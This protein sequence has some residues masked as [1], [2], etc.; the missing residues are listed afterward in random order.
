VYYGMGSVSSAGIASE[1]FDVCFPLSPLSNPEMLKSI[2]YNHMMVLPEHPDAYHKRNGLVKIFSDSGGFQLSKGVETFIEPDK[3]VNHYHRHV[4]YGIGLDIPLS[5]HLQDT[6]WFMRMAR[7]TALNDKYI[8][9]HLKSLNSEA[10]IYDVSHGLTLANRLRFTE[11][12]M[13]HKAGVGLALGGI[14]QAN[15]D[16]AFTSQLMAVVNLSAVLDLTKGEYERYHVLG[17][18]NPFMI[19][20]YIILTA[21]GMAPFISSD[22][23]TY[24]QA[25]ISHSSLGIRHTMESK[26]ANFAIPNQ[27]FSFA[28][29]CNCPICYVAGN[30][31]AFKLAAMGNALHGMHTMFQMYA[32]VN[33]ATVAM[34]KGQIKMSELLNITAPSGLTDMCRALYRFT[35]DMGNGFHPAWAKHREVLEGFLRKSS[36]PSGLFKVATVADRHLKAGAITTKAIERYEEFH[37]I[38]GKAKG[39]K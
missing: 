14:G 36:A 33:E 23:S 30:P 25:A 8:A 2:G 11:Y 16:T 20:I 10:A 15:Y 1:A 12:I 26:I 34:L 24:A 22:S 29:P 35:M 38:A 37:G 27:T 13:K 39:A 5:R 4:D 7:V 6:E 28:L 9:G 31:L 17:T 21:L 3:L 18:T 32:V 19:S